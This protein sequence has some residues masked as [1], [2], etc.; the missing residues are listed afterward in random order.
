MLAPR[1]L[2][3]EVASRFIG[4]SA[5][6][7]ARGVVLG[8]FLLFITKTKTAM[9]IGLKIWKHYARNVIRFTILGVSS[10]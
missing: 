6:I 3:G 7:V 10:R 9:T 4:D 5:G 2:D 8:I 1:I